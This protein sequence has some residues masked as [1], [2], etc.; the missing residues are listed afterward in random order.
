MAQAW[1]HKGGWASQ[2]AQVQ[3]ANKLN[4]GNVALVL[5]AGVS[6]FYGLPGWFELLTNLK[7]KGAGHSIPEIDH[8]PSW[9][10]GILDELFL[11]DEAEFL[12]AVHT[13]LYGPDS[14]ALAI[15]SIAD[16]PSLR[17]I[18]TMGVGAHRGTVD[19]VVTFNYDSLLESYFRHHGFS[20]VPVISENQPTEKADITVY[21]PHG[22]LPH[23]ETGFA[24]SQDIVLAQSQYEKTIETPW[25]STLENLFATRFC[26]FVGLSGNDERLVA[27]LEKVHERNEH[28]K[29][30]R[31]W[32]YRLC[33]KPDANVDLWDKRGVYS[34]EFEDLAAGINETLLN[35]CRL[36]A[37]K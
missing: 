18:G 27:L 17:A 30:E 20:V 10:Q 31:Y 6:F 16:D 33:R 25:E 28:A 24:R 36:A 11:G 34:V 35:I 37:A 3:I 1:P 19:T 26:I 23:P 15:Q 14:E 21:H 32:G 29:V 22:F 7:N 4:S 8:Y 2:E 13:G 9:A 12:E 5:G